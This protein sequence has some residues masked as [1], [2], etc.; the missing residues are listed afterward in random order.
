MDKS[1]DLSMRQAHGKWL[2]RTFSLLTVCLVGM[3]CFSIRECHKDGSVQEPCQD[4]I[5]NPNG[6]FSIKCTD[7]RQTLTFPPGWTWAKCSCPSKP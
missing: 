2:V 1:V 7:S 3:I 6:R 4:E 5:I